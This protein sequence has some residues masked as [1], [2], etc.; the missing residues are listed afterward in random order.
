LVESDAEY[1]TVYP[2]KNEVSG[3]AWSRFTGVERSGR[4]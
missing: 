1:R 2:G 4:N 3:P